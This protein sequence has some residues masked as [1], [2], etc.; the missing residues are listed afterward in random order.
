MSEQ[1]NLIEPTAADIVE[2]TLYWGKKHG[3]TAEQM[4]HLTDAEVAECYRLAQD[5]ALMRRWKETK[6]EDQR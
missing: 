5:Y 3:K 6:T 1:P 2:A 4:Q